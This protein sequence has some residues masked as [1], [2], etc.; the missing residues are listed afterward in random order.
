[1]L[2]CK[3][4]REGWFAICIAVSMIVGWLMALTGALK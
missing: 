2:P 1:M 4:N 3:D